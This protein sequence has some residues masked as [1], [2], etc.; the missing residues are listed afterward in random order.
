[1]R[2]SKSS[3]RNSLIKKYNVNPTKRNVN[4]T[5]RNVNNT[6]RN[7]NP[8]K[9][10]V[11]PTKKLSSKVRVNVGSKKEKTSQKKGTKKR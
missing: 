6:K 3:I 1:M 10:N 9:R 5:K 11:N 7:V 4:N 2:R 8:T